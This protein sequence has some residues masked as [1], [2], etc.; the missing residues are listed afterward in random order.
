[1]AGPERAT[2]RLMLNARAML[3]VVSLAGA[4]RAS[5]HFGLPRTPVPQSNLNPQPTPSELAALTAIYP[6]D[7]DVKNAVK[8]VIQQRCE[9]AK[10]I[11]REEARELFLTNWTGRLIW[12]VVHGILGLAIYLSWREFAAAREMRI[13]EASAAPTAAAGMKPVHELSIS[14]QGVALKTSLN[15]TLLMVF[16]LAFYFLYLKYVFPVSVVSTAGP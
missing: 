9:R 1:M 6:D 16:A 14:M 13:T 4:Q 8:S 5:A 10:E 7:P 2:R 12:L 11:Y 3:I 15:G